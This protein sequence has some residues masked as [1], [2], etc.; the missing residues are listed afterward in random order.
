MGCEAQELVVGGREAILELEFKTVILGI[1]E[2]PLQ[3]FFLISIS[4]N[5]IKLLSIDIPISPQLL[6]SKLNSGHW[7]CWC[8]SAILLAIQRECK[9]AL[10]S[11]WREPTVGSLGNEAL[12]CFLLLKTL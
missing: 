3:L 11:V 4:E 7:E 10:F 1:V 5:K 2:S 12:S 8:L 9:G 6:C